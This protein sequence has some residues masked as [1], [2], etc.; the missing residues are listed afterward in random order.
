MRENQWISI[1]DERKLKIKI[2]DAG[3]EMKGMDEKKMGRGSFESF[4]MPLVRKCIIQNIRS[5]F[6]HGNS[7]AYQEVKTLYL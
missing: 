3:I 5:L 1:I 4:Y 7:M 6:K 2:R